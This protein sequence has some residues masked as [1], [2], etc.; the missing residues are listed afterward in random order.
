MSKFKVNIKVEYPTSHKIIEFCT[1]L[2]IFLIL[3]KYVQFDILELPSIA[4]HI[5][6]L[7]F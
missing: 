6:K 4:F 2:V 3:G 5:F 7:I 1:I